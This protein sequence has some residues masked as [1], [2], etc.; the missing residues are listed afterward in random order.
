MNIE[1]KV[2]ITA[3]D[4]TVHTEE[5]GS[6]TK[7]WETIGEIGLSISESKGLLLKLQQ[8]IVAA[9]CAA[10]CAKQSKCKSCGRGLR[11]K[12]RE[13]IRY[14]TAFGDVAVPSPRF[15]RCQCHNSSAKTKGIENYKPIRPTQRD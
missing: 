1:I 12:A 10:F 2:A 15:Y 7:G 14:R 8:E 3:P 9:Q 11:K 5:I 4:G 6:L 13:Q